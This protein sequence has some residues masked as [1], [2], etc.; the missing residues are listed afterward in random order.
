MF[1]RKGG[2]RLMPL[3]NPWHS[4]VWCQDPQNS[5][6]SGTGLMP[7]AKRGQS[8]VVVVEPSPFVN[9]LVRLSVYGSRSQIGRMISNN[10]IVNMNCT[11]CKLKLNFQDHC[12]SE[13]AWQGTWRITARNSRV[14]FYLV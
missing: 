7:S 11:R 5:F 13:M 4:C 6:E 12:S 8:I 3:R 2:I 9:V 10:L 14:L 1:L